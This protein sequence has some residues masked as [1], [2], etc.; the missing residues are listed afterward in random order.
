MQ[1][2]NAIS[3]YI[4]EG[5]LQPYILNYLST[6]DYLGK[7]KNK[8]VQ[9]E[10][11]KQWKEKELRVRTTSNTE[12][13][14]MTPLQSLTDIIRSIEVPNELEEQTFVGIELTP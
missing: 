1:N 11:I 6:F 13:A 3:L 9:K 2:L 4:K 5:E 8:D 7:L 10:V 14:L 12:S